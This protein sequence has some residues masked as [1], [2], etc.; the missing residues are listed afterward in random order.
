MY[1][2]QDIADYLDIAKST[3]ELIVK[4]LNIKP[5]KSVALVQ[6]RNEDGSRKGRFTL[7]P[8]GARAMYTDEDAERII[9]EWRRRQGARIS[10]RLS[11][12]KLPEALDTKDD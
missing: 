12:Q 6:K 1:R 7:T 8:E 9:R 10:R 2:L 11:R 5:R 3:A 4:A